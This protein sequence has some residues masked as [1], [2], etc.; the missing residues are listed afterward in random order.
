[1][2]TRPL[3]WCAYDHCCEFAP[4]AHNARYCPTH[5]CKR[6]A[7][8]A[9]KRLTQDVDDTPEVLWEEQEQAKKGRLEIAQAKNEWLLARSKIAFFDLETTNLNAS[10]GMILCGCIGWRAR[11]GEPGSILTAVANKGNDGLLSDHAV[12]LT[13]RDALETADYVV[14]WYGTKFDIPYIN[15]RLLMHDERPINRLRHVDLYYSARFRLRLHSNRLQVAAETL[16]DKSDKTR[17]IGGVWQRAAQ[18]SDEDMKYIIEHCKVDVGELE[19]V[20]DQ[21]RGFVNFS[22]TR[23]RKLGGSY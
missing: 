20:F 12:C 8:N 23:W 13:L 1:M 6:R 17:V 10:I 9:V 16:L 4:E 19:Q 7:E 18:G 2:S 15:T 22:A 11:P 14:T 3:I 5:R 21:L